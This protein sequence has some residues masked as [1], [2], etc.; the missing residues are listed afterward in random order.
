MPLDPNI[1]LQA[2]PVDLQSAGRNVLLGAQTMSNLQSEALRR[3]ALAQRIEQLGQMFP[4]EMEKAKLT[5]SLLKDTGRLKSIAYG[6]LQVKPMIDSGNYDEAL[7]FAENRAKNLEE[8]GIDNSDTMQLVE[9]LKTGQFGNA[10]KMVD[11]AI[12]L[13]YQA[14]VLTPPETPKPLTTSNVM[15]I[16]EG[17]KQKI[18]PVAEAI[19]KQ[20]AKK[21]PLVKVDIGQNKPLS[22]SDSLNMV[23]DQGNHP[24]PGIPILEAV[25]AG[26][27]P[28][29]TEDQKQVR[30]SQG[31]KELLRQLQV[32][33]K[34]ADAFSK[35][36]FGNRLA[37]TAANAFDQIT[38]TNT[39]LSAFVDTRKATLS[40]LVRALGEKGTLTVQDVARINNA[41]PSASGYDL[42]QGKLVDTND[43]AAAKWKSLGN[44]ID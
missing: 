44:I 28:M 18:V 35:P 34:E 17:E 3:D 25:N 27:K 32:L 10:G 23:D 7:K 43:I 11:G 16:Q 22:V 41:I 33:S 26:F 20:P 21:E 14:G 9:A 4:Q 29:G 31:A 15:A 6:A 30:A 40:L 1:I 38:G 24:Q 5:N 2:Q 12:Q 36:G 39:N 42:V 37:K 8:A 13:G 19:G